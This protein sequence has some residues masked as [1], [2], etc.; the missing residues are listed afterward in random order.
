MTAEAPIKARPLA[1]TEDKAWIAQMVETNHYPGGRAIGNGEWVAV[2]PLMFTGA[3][4]KGS[5]GEDITYDDR[6]CYQSVDV[7][8][9]AIDE[10]EKRQFEGEP[11]DWSTHDTHYT[12]E[13]MVTDIKKY[14]EW[15]RN[16]LLEGAYDG[17]N[18]KTRPAGK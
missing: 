8:L 18:G 17:W 15:T 5:V 16:P 4:I 12:R 6:W 3:I 10:W 1:S 14:F 11:L 7:A 9:L 13:G 2:M